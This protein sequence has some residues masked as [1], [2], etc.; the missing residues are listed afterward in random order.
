MDL[1]V[2]SVLGVALAA[3]CGWLVVL[4]VRGRTAQ[5][6]FEILGEVAR[7]SEAAGSLEETLT[8]IC[9]V[10][11]PEIADFCAIDVIEGD[12]ARRVAVRVAPGAAAE[13]ER[14]L[15]ERKPSVPER[16]VEGDDGDSLDP[17]F[18]ERMSEAHLR[19][20]AHDDGPDLEFLRGMGVRS[21]ITL[22][23]QARGQVKGALTLG[24]AWSGRHYRRSDAHFAWILAGRVALALDNGGLFADL[25]R[26]E[27]ERA[28][29]AET[30]QHGLLPPPLPHL[31]GWSLAAM[32]QP[33]GAENEVGGDF[34]DAF[35]VPGGWMLV[36]GDVT[37]RGAE[38]ASITALARYTLR[39]A[40]VLTNDP[41]VALATLNRAL[42]ARG[43]T[44][45]CSVAA[46]AL[47]EDPEQPVRLAVAGHLPPLLVDG[48]E[49]TEIAGPD[50]V[51]GAFPDVEWRI[52][53]TAFK[54]GQQIVLVTDGIIEAA[55]GQDRFGEKRLR[56]ELAG[57]TNPA[58]A[59]QRLEAALRTFTAGALDDDVAV[60]ALTRSDGERFPAAEPLGRPSP[61]KTVNDAY[62]ALV[63][64]LFHAFNQRDAV[65]IVSLC[66]PEME[67]LT[68]TGGE[69]GHD[70][71]Y[72]GPDGLREYLADV[73]RV[74]EA[75]L[76]TPGT[77]E[78][79]GGRLL[80]SGRVY[81]RSRELG[82]RD[83]P[84]AW[85]WDVQDGLFVRG[86]VFVDPA[87]AILRFDRAAA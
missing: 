59:V 35:R 83:M 12:H 84:V 68:V 79:R 9:D 16:M 52:E 26:A 75:L 28:E 69:V 53:Q 85:I 73:E 4:L 15:L 5:H 14:G 24:V 34:Y 29:I 30:L 50:P 76:I 42:L 38:A 71:P 49:V 19:A 22:A 81:V 23:L 64:R 7:A 10:L 57:A 32:Y 60:L 58:L 17:R 46:L 67:F 80:A 54:P 11:V 82:I 20:L 65:A 48:E 56:A 78:R 44:A 21:A 51:L 47:S 43:G 74:W 1:I 6:R 3:L 8:A 86:E 77:V 62:E 63:G 41:E 61:G 66:A 25:E 72:R 87:E 2:I 39:T 70:D 31:P 27:R 40:A 37:G 45:L 13:I 55:N 33:A 36:I 18:I